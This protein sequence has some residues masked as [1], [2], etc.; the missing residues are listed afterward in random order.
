MKAGEVAFVGAL[1]HRNPALM[2]LLK[3]HLDDFDAV[4][5]HLLLADVTRWTV[6]R[7]QQAQGHQDLELQ[8]VLEDLENA[9]SNKSGDA[10][11]LVGVSFLENLPSKGQEGFEVRE[12]LGPTMTSHVEEHLTW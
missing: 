4:L 3:E 2:P 11:E 8:A 10:R 6:E 9:F 5:P 12:L 1:I 7:A